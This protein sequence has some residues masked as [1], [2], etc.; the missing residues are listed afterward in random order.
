MQQMPTGLPAVFT[1]EIEGEPPAETVPHCDHYERSAEA[2]PLAW[3]PVDV[4]PRPHLCGGD[5]KL[6]DDRYHDKL[7][8]SEMVQSEKL[9]WQRERQRAADPQ[10]QAELAERAAT[11]NRQKE[12]LEAERVRQKTFAAEYFVA[13]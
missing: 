4:N 2:D 12:L 6:L 11:F 9:Y 3:V 8:D 10:Y 13:Y 7:L 5:P 1:P